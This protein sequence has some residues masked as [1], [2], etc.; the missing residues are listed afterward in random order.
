MKF[1][2]MNQDP[3]IMTCKILHVKAIEIAMGYFPASVKYT[4]H[5]V[6]SFYKNY[7]FFMEQIVTV[8]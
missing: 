6:D 5:L 7:K 1:L 3:E 2:Q 4:S 8:P